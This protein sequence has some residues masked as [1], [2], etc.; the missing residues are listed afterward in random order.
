M[1]IGIQGI[2]GSFHDAATAAYF[3]GQP[4][5]IVPFAGFRDLARALNNQSLDY[6]V[7]AIE[8][9]IA[10]S[11]LPNYALINEFGLEISGEVFS[12]IE[13]CFL[14]NKGIT[15]E[16]I[17]QV[18]SHPMALLQ[19]ADY[20][21]KYQNIKI[22]ES[23]DTADSAKAIK[24][25]NLNHV[26]AIAS[27][28]AA[29]LFDLDVLADN[30]ETNKLNYTRF[31]II[32]GKMNG[33]G[34]EKEKASLRLITSHHPGS[35]ADILTVFKQYQINLTKIQSMPIV[36]EPYNYAF[37]IDLVW[38]DYEKYRE[39]LK[40]IEKISAEVKILGEYKKGK[41]PVVR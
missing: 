12:R 7:M 8:N 19:S 15:I 25:D 16:E 24:E 27:K 22:V 20:L 34:K 18:R 29:E 35:L 30:I 9:T 4:Y 37:N 36:G 23:E 32:K 14:V 28:R 10:G 40:E 21:S 3:A 11:L 17:T 13:L 33:V 41:M 6:G 38:E 2:L 39:A 26:A 1:K 31:L 5:E